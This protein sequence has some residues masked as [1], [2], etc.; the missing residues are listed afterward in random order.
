MQGGSSGLYFFLFYSGM[1]S[2]QTQKKKKKKSSFILCA[3]KTFIRFMHSIQYCLHLPFQ[4][5]QTLCSLTKSWLQP[6][7]FPPWSPQALEEMLKFTTTSDETEAY[8]LMCTRLL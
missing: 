5:P 6:P 8:N 3:F 2:Q 1:T 7:Y 4:L